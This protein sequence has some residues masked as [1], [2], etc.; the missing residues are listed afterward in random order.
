MDLIPWARDY[1]PAGHRELLYPVTPFVQ[2]L[3]EH[4]RTHPGSRATAAGFLAYPSLLPVYG[5]AEVRVDNPVAD[6]RYLR[7]LDAALGFRPEGRRYKGALTNVD[8]PLL[9]FLGVS[10]LISSRNAPKPR[11]WIRLDRNELAPLRLFEN[12]SPLPRWFLPTGAEM[13]PPGEPW[14]AVAELEDPHRVVLTAGEIPGWR[15]PERPWDAEAVRWTG[16]RGRLRLKFPAGGWKLIASSIP[17]SEGWRAEAGGRRLRTVPVSSA[18]LGVLAGPETS[19]AEVVFVPPGFRTGAGL[20]AA[21]LLT[22]TGL[23]LQSAFHRAGH[24]QHD[25]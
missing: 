8:S 6:I 1:L 13:A 15:P 17:Y 10:L 24:R 5:I 2:A 22:L 3:Q 9:D 16:E 11:H 7:V 20:C 4:A 19:S 23:G 25:S 18:F 12:P 21:A 14:Q